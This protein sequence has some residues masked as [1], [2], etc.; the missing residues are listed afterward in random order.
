MRG[1]LIRTKLD[2]FKQSVKDKNIT[3]IGIGISTLPLI[4]YLVSLGANVTACDRHTR[5]DLGE[6]AAELEGMGAVLTLG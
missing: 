1:C 2:E 3:V 4:K 6:V 5:E